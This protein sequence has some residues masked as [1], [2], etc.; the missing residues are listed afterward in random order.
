MTKPEIPSTDYIYEE[1]FARTIE[2]LYAHTRD[3][4]PHR[5]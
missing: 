3:Q 2:E 4:G 5:Q 1:G